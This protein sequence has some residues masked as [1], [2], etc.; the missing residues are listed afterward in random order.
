MTPRA[1]TAPPWERP[2]Q[3]RVAILESGHEATLARFSTGASTIGAHT[4]DIKDLK[5][6]GVA[7]K[8]EVETA[9][10]ALEK[11]LEG[12]V[13]KWAAMT[14]LLSI[15]GIAGG[16]W[17]AAQRSQAIEATALVVTGLRQ[18]VAEARR[19]VSEQGRALDR[20]VQSLEFLAERAKSQDAELAKLRDA[21]T[22]RR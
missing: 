20:A 9:G 5:T 14:L 2:L 7:L 13:W 21:A 12:R 3:E 11:K 4:D 8:K 16:A 6:A 15:S 19:E 17:W 1:P 22:R 10:A 18:D